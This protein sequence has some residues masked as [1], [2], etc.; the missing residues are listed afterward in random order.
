[1]SPIGSEWVPGENGRSKMWQFLIAAAGLMIV[2]AVGDAIA[3]ER[4]HLVGASDKVSSGIQQG[5][6]NM[7]YRVLRVT[8]ERDGYEF[9]IVD[10]AGI[11]VDVTYDAV[12]GELVK[13]KLD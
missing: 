9:C 8:V 4:P 1:M 2:S 12:T 10:D 6:E 3:G 5:L 7:G 13:A 11:P